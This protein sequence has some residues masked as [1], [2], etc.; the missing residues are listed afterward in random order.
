[1]DLELSANELW[2]DASPEKLANFIVYLKKTEKD[3]K[4][5]RI[6]LEEPHYLQLIELINKMAE[7][8]EGKEELIDIRTHGDF[9]SGDKKT[10]EIANFKENLQ[11]LSNEIILKH[12]TILLQE[13]QIE[14]RK[15]IR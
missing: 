2:K 12:Y 6:I 13:I 15:Q 8:K 14:F 9:N 1:M 4:R 11:V 5:N 10:R 3:I 7:Y